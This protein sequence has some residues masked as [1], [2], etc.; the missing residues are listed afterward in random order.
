MK[1]PW[2]YQG[3]RLCPRRGRRTACPPKVAL[4]ACCNDRGLDEKAGRAP[5][6]GQTFRVILTKASENDALGLNVC[7]EENA[8]QV[9]GIDKPSLAHSWNSENPGAHV[10]EN[11]RVVAVNGVRG[12]SRELAG[13]LKTEGTLEL[14]VIRLV[15]SANMFDGYWRTG[16]RESVVVRN[17]LAHF[18]DQTWTFDVHDVDCITIVDPQGRKRYQAA[19]VDDQLRWDD[20]DVWVRD[21]RQYRVDGSGLTSLPPPFRKGIHLRTGQELSAWAP[22]DEETAEQ[23]EVRWGTTVT[24]HDLENGWAEVHGSQ[25]AR[26]LPTHVEGVRVLIPE[27]RA[28][29]SA[30]A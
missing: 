2:Q 29:A 21:Y 20:Q 12:A 27:G 14:L 19:F 25:A 8:L 30:G 16:S 26:Y 9:I 24:A 23:F 11:D 28:P 22:E 18:A 5:P 7:R 3:M 13:L 4:V 15:V 6:L 10:R 17:S 1:P